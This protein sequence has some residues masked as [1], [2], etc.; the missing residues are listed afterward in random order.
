MN[1]HTGPMITVLY[2]LHFWVPGATQEMPVRLTE[3]SISGT[4]RFWH[5]ST[6]FWA[7]T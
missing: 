4:L 3:G 1:C 6:S 2:P 7:T 5:P